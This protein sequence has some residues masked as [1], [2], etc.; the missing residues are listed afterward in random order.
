MFSEFLQDLD[1]RI[2][3]INPSSIPE[4]TSRPQN[5]NQATQVLYAT[6][7]LAR[8]EMTIKRTRFGESLEYPP[9]PM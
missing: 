5:W 2:M 4:D 8:D 3:S 6:C 1:Y 7:T 9:P